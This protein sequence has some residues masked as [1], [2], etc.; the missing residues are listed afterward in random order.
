MELPH[1]VSVTDAVRLNSVIKRTVC[2]LHLAKGHDS[3]T[4]RAVAREQRVRI[5]RFRA[6]AGDPLVGIAFGA[7]CISGGCLYLRLSWHREDRAA[8]ETGHQLYWWQEGRR[9]RDRAVW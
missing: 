1:R 3:D 2:I 9:L 4:R 6:E 7:A 8:G 5:R